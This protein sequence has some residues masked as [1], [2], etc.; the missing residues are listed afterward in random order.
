MKA[1]DGRCRGVTILAG[2]TLAPA[3]LFFAHSLVALPAFPDQEVRGVKYGLPE[4]K[5]IDEKC[6]NCH[7][8]K[9]I[10]DA[11]QDRKD[12]ERVLS[13]MEKKGVAL[14]ESD[15]RVIGHFWQKKLFREKKGAAE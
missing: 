8:R 1:M 9:R 14:T 12:M 3:L 13:V 4:L 7:N 11:V 15:R 5:V 6:L 10:D 2:R